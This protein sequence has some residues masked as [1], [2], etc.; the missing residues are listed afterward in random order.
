LTDPF[1]RVIMRVL[2]LVSKY[3]RGKELYEFNIGDGSMTIS[4]RERRRQMLYDEILA[5]VGELLA[6][7]GYSAMSMDELAARVG[8]SKPTLYSIFPAKEDLLVAAVMHSMDQV[9]AVIQADQTPRSPLQRLTFILRTVIQMQVNK[10][11]LTP[12]QWSPEVFQVIC[13]RKEVVQRMQGN[14]AVLADLIQ[15]AI[16][17]GEINSAL[18]PVLILR[19]FYAML[20]ALHMSFLGGAGVPNRD[21][22][23]D[24]L[25]TIFE[26]G[27]R[28]PEP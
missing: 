9:S 4:L 26:R 25:V 8:I 1:E 13:M 15:Q 24:T 11:A 14:E 2:D 10:G 3:I 16:S 12:R 23:V 7:K 21:T 27:V 6:E 18:D 5:A 28:A 20:N 17:S 19:A 22:V